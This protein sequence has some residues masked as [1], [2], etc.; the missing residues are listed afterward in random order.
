[1][2]K[3]I[4]I[5]FLA[6][7]PLDTTPL[8]L[9]AEVREIDNHIQM[10]KERDRFELIQQWAVTPDD[11]QRAL[12]RHQP[13]VVHFSGHGSKTHGIVLEDKF[14]NSQLVGK[15]ELIELFKILKDNI[16]VVVLNACYS[17]RQAD[18]LSE[19]IDY[20]I[21][22]K[23]TISDDH[24]ILFAASFYQGLA[25]S[26]LVK[27]AFDLANIIL[28][29]KGLARSKLPEMLVRSVP[30]PPA[31]WLFAKPMRYI[32]KRTIAQIIAGIILISSIYWAWAGTN[33]PPV[34]ELSNSNSRPEPPKPDPERAR[35]YKEAITQL[36]S[37][38]SSV[39]S[40]TDAISGLREF[41][42]D[43]DSD[44]YYDRTILTLVTFIREN[45]KPKKHSGDWQDERISDDIQAALK[46][47]GWRKHKWEGGETQ[48]LDLSD[49]YLRRA[50]LKHGAEPAGAHLEWA[51]LT[52]ANLERAMLRGVNLEAAT[53]RGANLKNAILYKANLQNADLRDADLTGA[54][55]QQ[56]TGLTPEQ[57]KEAK[58][59]EKAYF[60]QA[61]EDLLRAS[62]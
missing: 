24:A 53:L 35:R 56:V 20:T 54:D 8:H 32:V 27:E 34:R 7:S 9:G 13:H 25:H 55:L 22:V 31:P 14:G 59:W 29:A 42:I 11:L 49:T 12:L 48:K 1:M 15:P 52:N 28:K 38:D 58:N 33:P 46:V 40:R 37:K 21:G 51:M 36:N 6:A 19:V 47:L 30:S 60:S 4:K 3:K 50:D 5:L 43:P 18:G 16:R 39:T 44:E 41:A 61:F 45:S 10:A 62:K 23:T 57:I 17:R 2:R 26:R